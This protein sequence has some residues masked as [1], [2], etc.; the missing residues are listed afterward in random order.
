MLA[1]VS[2]RLLSVIPI[3]II[4]SVLVFSLGQLIPGDPAVT[5]AGE[6]ASAE[7][8]ETI[9]QQLGLDRPLWE[10]Y[11]QWLA[12]ALRGD[13]GVS[14]QTSQSVTGEV[15]SSLPKTLFLV[16]SS[17]LVAVVV[18]GTLGASAAV[19]PHGAIDR[20][21]TSLAGFF[22]AVPSFVIALVLVAVFS[23]GLGLLPA[24]GFRLPSDGMGEAVR[25]V[26]LPALALGFGSAGEFAFQVRSAV[27]ASLESEYTLALQSRQVSRLRIIFKHGLRNAAIPLTTVL[28]LIFNHILGAAV[29]VEIIFAIPGI[30]ALAVSAV[31]NSDLPM[32][33]GVV[34]VFAVLTLLAN[35]TCDLLYGVLDPRIRT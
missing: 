12:N 27:R 34:I 4:V 11:G 13:L 5:L 20:V 29:V 35:L 30:G 31:T 23:I 21:V 26:V 7:L 24:T 15:L 8:I 9:R 28:A 17:L 19:R 3:L 2:R 14:I 32:I 10:Q 25:F 1:L 6:Q 22:V 33:Q 18:G 16:F